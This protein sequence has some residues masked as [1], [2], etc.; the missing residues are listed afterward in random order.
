[1]RIVRP[2]MLAANVPVEQ[3]QRDPLARRIVRPA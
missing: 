2:I 1:M 3:L